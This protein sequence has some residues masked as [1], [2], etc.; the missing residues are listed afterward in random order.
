MFGKYTDKAMCL[1]K[2]WRKKQLQSS[3]LNYF[4][5]RILN[6]QY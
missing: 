4:I 3:S 1:E 5:N 2:A 6:A